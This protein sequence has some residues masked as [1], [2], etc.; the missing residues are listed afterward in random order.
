MRRVL[1]AVSGLLAACVQSTGPGGDPEGGGDSSAPDA[2]VATGGED[3]GVDPTGP[4]GLGESPIR[5]VKWKNV[6]HGKDMAASFR[7]ETAGLSYTDAVAGLCAN[8]V[9]AV[10]LKQAEPNIMRWTDPA[11]GETGPCNGR[12]DAWCKQRINAEIA[13]MVA[14]I[15]A[16]TTCAEKPLVYMWQRQWFNQAGKV[17]AYAED[18]AAVIRLL[19]DRHIADRLAGIAAIESHLDGSCQTKNTA[20][21]AARAVNARTGGWLRSRSFFFP[22]AGMGAYFRN[23]DADYGCMSGLDF[24]RR[25]EDEVGTFSFIYKEMAYPYQGCGESE[26]QDSVGGSSTLSVEEREE[27]LLRGCLGV[28]DL[29][30]LV[31]AAAADH[32]AVANVT[33]WGDSGDGI[34]LIPQPTLLALH[35]I[36]VTGRAGASRHHFFDMTYVDAGEC[37]SSPDCGKSLL[38]VSGGRAARNMSPSAVPTPLTVFEDWTGWSTDD[39]GY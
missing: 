12:D 31:D 24:L 4:M 37:P 33:F 2:A 10:V 28:A 27:W 9:G 16:D 22:G 29:V 14:A 8:G 3:A 26:W 39:P 25:I 15:D 32:P 30:R 38:T 6:M 23:I 20:L 7:F 36:L 11:T 34:H 5:G 17:E 21:A 19:R 13:D 35:S 1:L 18:M